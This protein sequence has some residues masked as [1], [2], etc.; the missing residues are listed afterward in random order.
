MK[1]MFALLLVI[2]WNSTLLYAAD[3]DL[4][5]NGNL[6]AGTT[7]PAEKL[8]VNGNAKV[9]G[10]LGIQGTAVDSRYG[11]Y[12]NKSFMDP[13]T[14]MG[15]YLLLYPT[16]TVNNTAIAR[17]LESIVMPIINS[18]HTNSGSVAGVRGIAVRNWG[19]ANSDDNGTL[20][21]IMGLCSLYGNNSS[22]PSAT[23][24]TNFAYGILV[25]PYAAAG[26]ILNMYDIY[27]G[28]TSAGGTVTNR[29]GIYQANSANNHFGGNVGIGTTNMGTGGTGALVFGNGAKPGNLAGV[30]GL[31]AKTD[32]GNTHL[33]VF[34]SDS[35][36][37]QLSPHAQDAPDW[38]Y[39]PEDEIP[40]MIKEIQRYL[41]YVRYTNQ[42]RQAR[43]ASM[44]DA[45]KSA[46]SREQRTCV[47]KESFAD[48]NARLGLSG[49]KALVQL[50]WDTEQ[51]AIKNARDAE[52]LTALKSQAA[53]QTA[54]T[55]AVAKGAS[56]G[57]DSIEAEAPVQIPEE[58]IIQPM[59]ARLRAAMDASTR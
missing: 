20:Q 2:L 15:T 47:F 21:S 29:W 33:W 39:D 23:P 26:T 24:I 4:I 56:A 40:I 49:D 12:S 55:M 13:S 53:Q 57:A 28:A 1:K 11:M 35:P 6:G 44:T 50:D 58:Y 38:M 48:H 30:A 41:G 10:S 59:P 36:D 54:K 43:L 31:Y 46:L 3:G 8:D 51:Q 5:V 19:S 27:L 9:A 52:R 37:T 17:G 42:T 14:V 7:T 25:M 32:S 22:N 45:E 18:G 34:D 16:W